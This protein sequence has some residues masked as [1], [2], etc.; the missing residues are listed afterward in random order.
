M[1]EV[2]FMYLLHATNESIEVV[3][4]SNIMHCALTTVMHR[5]APGLAPDDKLLRMPVCYSQIP[6][7]GWEL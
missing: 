7:E 4:C 1:S 2:Q 6:W 3:T 5:K